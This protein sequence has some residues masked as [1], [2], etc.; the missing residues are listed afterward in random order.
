M[1]RHW[2]RKLLFFPGAGY[3]MV[4]AVCA[5]AGYFFFNCQKCI[6]LCNP[7]ASDLGESAG[8]DGGGNI[9]CRQ[10]GDGVF[11]YW[12]ERL[13]LDFHLFLPFSF[14]GPPASPADLKKK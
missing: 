10:L 6:S 3:G 13:S 5:G 4:L 11:S 9:Q 12:G 2:G 8:G 14:S 7:E 1:L